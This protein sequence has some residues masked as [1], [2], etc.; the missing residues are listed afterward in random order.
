M[1]QNTVIE[2]LGRRLRLGVIGGGSGSFIGAMHRQ[3]A[4]LDGRFEIV[5]G[6]LSS[7]PDKAIRDGEL[8]GLPLDR[9]YTD[10]MDLIREESVRPD[11]AEVVAIMTPND[12]H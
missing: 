4:T 9:I 2:K 12:S 7:R 8:I 1:N 10:A 5:A 6:A 3:A 11:G